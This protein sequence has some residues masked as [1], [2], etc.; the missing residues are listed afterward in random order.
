MALARLPET[1]L[2]MDDPDA[3]AGGSTL[4]DL[5]CGSTRLLR[6]LLVG[7]PDGLY[8]SPEMLRSRV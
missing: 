7:S 3:P 4:V 5:V 6:H 1:D 2:V 8:L